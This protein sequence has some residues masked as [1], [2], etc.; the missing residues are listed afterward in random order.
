[1]S[2]PQAIQIGSL[3]VSPPLALA[4]MTGLTNSAFRRLILSL[5]GCGLVTTEMVSAAAFTPKALRSHRLL[6]LHPDEH[7]IAVQISGHD[8]EQVAR[9]AA[10]AAER[11]ADIVDLNAG[12][13]SRQ[14]TGNGSGAALLRDLGRL[15]AILQ[16]MKRSLSIPVTLKFRSGWDERS[17]VAVEV[18]RLAEACGCAA[19]TLHPR[20]RAQ[21][22]AGRAD[23]S[24]LAEVVQAVRIPVFASGDIRSVDDARRCFAETGCAGLMVARAALSNPWILSQIAAS[25]RGEEPPHPTLADRYRFLQQYVHLLREEL[26]YEPAILG[27]LKA[28]VGQ[29]HPGLPGAL[30]LRRKVMRSR[31]LDEAWAALTP[32]PLPLGVRGEEGVSPEPGYRNG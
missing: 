28:L 3:T 21:G 19:I 14:V 24:L 10:L 7:P 11:G 30:A 2:V 32:H 20:T 23:W 26:G 15:E 25:L 9:A 18:A 22:Y 6:D 4:P 29:M 5:G 1:M 17:I 13:P 16:M 12:C 8:P 31:T 27:R